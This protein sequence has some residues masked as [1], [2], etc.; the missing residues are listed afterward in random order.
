MSLEILEQVNDV[1]K[2][3][4]G[5]YVPDLLDVIAAWHSSVLNA[6][7]LETMDRCL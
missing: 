6:S 3:T 2:R 4:G 5:V 1:G 7:I